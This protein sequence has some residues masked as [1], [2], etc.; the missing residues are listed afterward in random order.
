MKNNVSSEINLVSSKIF[1][2]R[3]QKVMLDFDLAILYGTETKRLKEAVRRNIERF[4]SDFMFVLT[5][6]E[7]QVLRTQFAS[8]ELGK[9]KFS[10]YLPFA[11]TEQGVAMLSSV[12]NS[13]Q[14]IQMNIQIVRIIVFMRQYA[15]NHADLLNR[16]ENLESNQ[17]K[18]FKDIFEA[19][20][21]LMEK[22][23]LET[24]QSKRKVIGFKS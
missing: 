1:E 5:S 10:K 23:K 6:N 7:Y 19:I 14:A 20:S 24:N 15:L 4:P 17:N 8:L 3:G 2:V 9:G 11:F 18:L 21:Y 13:S 16:L 22:D 12:I